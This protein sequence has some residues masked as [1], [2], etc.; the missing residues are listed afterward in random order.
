MMIKIMKNENGN[1]RAKIRDE[2]DLRKF[3]ADTC[4][5]PTSEYAGF[6]F[7]KEDEGKEFEVEGRIL[8]RG[9]YKGNLYITY[10]VG[11]R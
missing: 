3:A 1:V 7:T 6:Y 5:A 8:S 2:M 11:L 10:V 4:L 9:R